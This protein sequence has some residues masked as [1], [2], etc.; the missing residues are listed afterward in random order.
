MAAD[1]S[2]ALVS[3]IVRSIP[4]NPGAAT[5]AIPGLPEPRILGKPPGLV[6]S[7]YLGTRIGPN[8]KYSAALATSNDWFMNNLWIAPRPMSFGSIISAKSITLRIFNTYRGQTRELQSIDETLMLSFGISITSGESFPLDIP[9]FAFEDITFEA[10]SAG[11]PAFEGLIEFEFDNRSVFILTNGRRLLLFPYEPEAGVMEQLSWITDIR[12]TRDGKEQRRSMR[13]T[14]RQRFLFRIRL[15]DEDATALRNLLMNSRTL[16][17]GIPV[18]HEAR[19]VTQAA[20]TGAATLQVSTSAVDHRLGGGLLVVNPDGTYF[21]NSIETFN[22]TSITMNAGAVIDVQSGASVMPIR[23]GYISR[24]VTHNDPKVNMTETTVEFLT[25]DN[26]ELGFADQTALEAEFV[27]HPNDGLPI[28]SDPNMLSEGTLQRS[29]E[30]LYTSL[31]SGI[32]QFQLLARE[33]SSSVSS[34]FS[35]PLHSM[36]AVWRWRQFLHW[37]RG[38]WGSFY[39]PTFRKDLVAVADFQLDS[40]TI[41]VRDTG[42]AGYNAA[43][44]H[45]SIMLELPDGTQYFAQINGI[46]PGTGTEILTFDTAFDTGDSTLIDSADAKISFLELVRLNGD[47]ATFIHERPGES[48]LRFN[49]KTVLQ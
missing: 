48:E 24:E 27:V 32:G 38:N 34:P 46:T 1:V 8:V 25:T 9:F 30:S 43:Q 7:V 39:L 10:D 28:L 14:P 22:S 40:G 47:A 16:V 18:W 19:R 3:S 17:F 15:I 41:T 26:V 49:V 31:D 23:Y 12:K 42:L 35:S 13:T 45:K 2:A 20:L 36:E 29:Y 11:P 37:V 33:P 21:D 4:G 5:P 44:P 6:G